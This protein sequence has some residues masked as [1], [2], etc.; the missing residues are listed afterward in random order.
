MRETYFLALKWG[1]DL[2]TGKYGIQQDSNPDLYDVT[3]VRVLSRPEYFEDF[4]S[5]LL[6][7]SS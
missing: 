7:W 6:K 5:L 2:Y 4:L 3:W 1:V